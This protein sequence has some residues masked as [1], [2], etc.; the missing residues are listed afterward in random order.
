MLKLRGIFD[1]D[2]DVPGGFQRLI[3]LHLEQTRCVVP[4][5]GEYENSARRTMQSAGDCPSRWG[6]VLSDCNHLPTLHDIRAS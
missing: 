3:V 2:G 6:K 1:V 4:L 5:V